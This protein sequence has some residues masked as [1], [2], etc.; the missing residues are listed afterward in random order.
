MATIPTFEAIL[1]QFHQNLCGSS[2][3]QT[4]KK[5]SFVTGQTS[6]ESQWDMTH[7]ILD[8]IFVALRLDSIDEYA[9]EGAK[10]NIMNMANAYREVSFN[11]FTF[12]ADAR[13]IIWD[14]LGYFFA[15]GAARIVAN[16]NLPEP[17]DNDM[18]SGK[19]WY[20]P[21]LAEG[22]DAKLKM[23]V[24][25]VVEWLLDL[26]GMPMEEFATER[27]DK[28]DEADDNVSES[29]IRSLYK[30][31]NG[32]LPDL[33]SIDLYFP[34]EMEIEYRGVFQVNQFQSPEDQFKAAIEF[35]K[36]RKLTPEALQVEIN[37]SDIGR[38]NTIIYGNVD[39]G[40]R[41]N[42]VKKLANRY[43][44]PLPSTIR[45]RLRIARTV[46]DG[47][48]RIL[49][50]LLPGVA[51]DC[52]D[53]EKNTVLQIIMQFKLIYNL[54]TEA[55]VQREHADE[56][57]ENEWFE[58]QLLKT[59]I[60]PELFLSILP[61]QR[62]TANPELGAILSRRFQHGLVAGRLPDLMPAEASESYVEYIGAFKQKLDER[63]NGQIRFD[64][65]IENLL[66]G[67]ITETLSA[68]DRYDML[69]AAVRSPD[70]TP[71]TY[72]EIFE[73]IFSLD[74]APWQFMQA[75]LFQLEILL[76][77]NAPKEHI[78]L[79]I[80]YAKSHLGYQIWKAPFLYNEGLHLIKCNDFGGATKCFREAE[81]D[82][83]NRSYG[84]LRGNIAQNL[85][86]L[87]VANQKLLLNNHEKHYRDMLN[88]YPLKPEEHKDFECMAMHVYEYFWAELYKPYQGVPSKKP[89]VNEDLEKLLEPIFKCLWEGD[90]QNLERW[91]KKNK[92]L[93]KKPLRYIRGDT[94]LTGLINVWGGMKG[95]LNQLPYLLQMQAHGNFR[96]TISTISKTAPNLLTMADFKGQT[97]LMLVAEQGEAELVQIMIE[98]GAA[99]A[100]Q[101]Y[102]GKSALHAAIVKEHRP[103]IEILLKYPDCATKETVFGETPAHSAALAGDAETL[104]ILL[105]M[106]PDVVQVQSVHGTPLERAETLLRPE[107][108]EGFCNFAQQNGAKVATEKELLACIKILKQYALS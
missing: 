24:A 21:E 9:V 100:A 23:P 14:I 80:K 54:T 6:L 25:Q 48:T 5:Q 59:L 41:A 36:T 38:I 95:Q 17:L 42:F 99:P 105:S 28:L 20:F 94:V 12:E 71:Q 55:S 35:V 69:Y 26:Q 82:C 49:K 63:Q 52:A 96:N 102:R 33:A 15:P 84:P 7:E 58:T 50:F 90:T 18:P 4:K 16:W 76:E 108:Q 34:D 64:S 85:F 47:Y 97:P 11:T 2:R 66:S 37:I 73:R 45:Q 78:D 67:N 104:K 79:S 43:V 107:F 3:Y 61:S 91:L 27:V 40:E 93:L 57:V 32:T 44:S 51:V 98:A 89:A 60:D 77:N 101:D 68:E 19:F 88:F 86:A 1:L 83:L 72:G 29:M 53:P 13:Q 75:W 46:Q 106:A 62:E 92:Q 22:H 70:L 103:V 39:E 65:L 56:K 87:E 8:D 31:R 81:K 30:W 74:L 10:F